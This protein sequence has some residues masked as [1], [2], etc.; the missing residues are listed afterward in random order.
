MFFDFTIQNILLIIEF[1]GDY[2][3][4]NPKFYKAD[5]IIKYPGNKL[6]KA[7][8]IWERDKVREQILKFNGYKLIT[9]WEDDYRK[10]PDL[11]LNYCLEQIEERIWKTK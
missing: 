3:H 7:K 4:A 8:E 10:D 2:W 9:V 11:V 1:N 6:I 5:D